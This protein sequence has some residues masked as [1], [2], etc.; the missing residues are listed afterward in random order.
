MFWFCPLLIA[1]KKFDVSFAIKYTSSCPSENTS[2][3]IIDHGKYATK[4]IFNTTVHVR[5]PPGKH[6][7][8]VSHGWCDF[9]KVQLDIDNNGKI[10]AVSNGTVLQ[11]QPFKIYHPKMED[12]T[13]PFAMMLKNPSSLLM[14]GGFFLFPFLTKKICNPAKMQ[15]MQQKLMEQQKELMQ[16]Q[17]AQQKKK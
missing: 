14:I 2:M 13:D 1:T 16:Q 9:Y 12:L 3:L 8:A 15:E 17:Q 6:V 10:K 11:E 4:G 7:A 5:L